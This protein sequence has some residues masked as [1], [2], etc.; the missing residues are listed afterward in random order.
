MNFL[1]YVR[2]VYFSYIDWVYVSFFKM[3]H[4]AL[5]FNLVIEIE[6]WNF[7]INFLTKVDTHGLTFVFSLDKTKKFVFFLDKDPRK[8]TFLGL[9]SEIEKFPTLCIKNF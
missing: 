1:V 4:R 7:R 6:G 3:I 2:K 5:Y 8:G 9:G